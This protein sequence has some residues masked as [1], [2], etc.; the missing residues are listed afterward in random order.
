MELGPKR[1]ADAVVL[2]PVG[3][4]DSTNYEEFKIALQPY[5]DRCTAHGDRLVLDF[6]RVEYISSAGLLALVL[7]GKQAA[8][9]GGAFVLAALQPFVQEVMQVSRLTTLLSIVPSTRDALAQIS[10][11]ALAAF[12]AG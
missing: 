1:F 12:T 3:R 6:S 5:V 8:A 11:A 2:S 4:I 9:Q 10:P 7:A